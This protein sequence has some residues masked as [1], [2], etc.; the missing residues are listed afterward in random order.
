MGYEL[1]TAAIATACHFGADAAPRVDFAAWVATQPEH[2]RHL[3][4]G[5][6]DGSNGYVSYCVMSSGSRLGYETRNEQ[7]VMIASFRDLMATVGA[8]IVIVDYGAD[9]RQYGED[10]ATVFYADHWQPDV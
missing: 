3:C 10:V 1:Q 4:A 6:F 9:M 8:D 7:L 5:P 2:L